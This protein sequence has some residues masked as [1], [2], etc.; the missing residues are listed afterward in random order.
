MQAVGENHLEQTWRHPQRIWS[1]ELEHVLVNVHGDNWMTK[2]ICRET[3]TRDVQTLV[4]I[5]V[6]QQVGPAHLLVT[7]PAVQ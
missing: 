1:K 5:A 7:R 4:Q 2:A 6:T 3:L